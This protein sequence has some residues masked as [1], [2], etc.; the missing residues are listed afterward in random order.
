MRTCDKCGCYIPDRWEVCP[1]C[2]LMT[3]D[4][5]GSGAAGVLLPGAGE[6]EY[7]GVVYATPEEKLELQ[8][9][10]ESVAESFMGL[11]QKNIYDVVTVKG[12]RGGNGF[13]VHFPVPTPQ[14]SIRK[15]IDDIAAGMQA[16]MRSREATETELR[17]IGM[18]Y[19]KELTA[20]PPMDQTIGKRLTA[21]FRR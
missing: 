12:S 5:G 3:A 9:T 21:G 17:L 10:I 16:I 8:A 1:A 19:E 14:V 6:N 18:G 15:Q 13:K 20:M 7:R 2:G 4:A 11:S